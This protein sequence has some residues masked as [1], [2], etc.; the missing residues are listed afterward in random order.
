MTC[1]DITELRLVSIVLSSK[2][3]FFFFCLLVIS[4]SYD[5]GDI[6]SSKAFSTIC[7]SEAPPGIMNTLVPFEMF[8]SFEAARA[9][10]TL[11]LLG[12]RFFLNMIHSPSQLS[13]K[14]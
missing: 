1:E 4:F 7:A 8:W 6:P 2:Y 10:A 11:E 12:R 14:H 9:K 3:S 13:V 5:L